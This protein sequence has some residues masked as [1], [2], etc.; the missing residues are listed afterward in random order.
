MTKKHSTKKALMASLLSL[1]LCVSML[2]GT[3]FAWFTDTVTSGS[4]VIQ[5]GSLDIVLEYWDGTQ[6][7]DAEGKV[8]KFL[9]A[10]G[11]D[12]EVL[13]EPGCTYQMPKI[14]VR[15][16]GTLAAYVLIRLNGIV[17][18]EKLLEVVKLTNTITNVP[19]SMLTGSQANVYQKFENATVDLMYG[20]P[21]GTLIFDW[22]LMG[23]GVV[24]PNSGNTDTTAE[25]TV[26]G[27]MDESAGNEYQDLKIEGI[28]VTVLATQ[29][30]YEY[31]S[32]G[33]EYDKEA[34]LPVVEIKPSW[35]GKTLEEPA[36]DNGVYQV[37]KPSELA[38]L[39]EGSKTV[40]KIKFLDNIDMAGATIDS[41]DLT[42]YH[43]VDG[44]GKKISNI[45]VN[46]SGLFGN[47]I[48][49]GNI[50]NIILD[51]ITVNTASGDYAGV[52]NGKYSGTYTDVTVQN[53][54]VNAPASEYVG[55]MAGAYYK[56]ITGCKVD[57]VSVTGTEKV[58]GLIGFFT[59]A[60]IGYSINIDNC[61]VNNVT[62]TATNTSKP[63]AGVIFGRGLATGSYKFIF[64]NCSAGMK[65]GQVLLGQ[66]YYNNIDTSAITV[67]TIS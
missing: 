67:T 46:G 57:N 9:K 48:A 29:T 59:L 47:V 37:S 8:L 7:L 1:V 2:M 30:V 33:R 34:K 38:W 41:I 28:S 25:F 63:Y 58:G 4:N 12:D 49:D 61:S 36:I 20:T 52:V 40:Q 10:D 3:T 45:V 43:T 16:V 21:D 6:W 64:T 65:A 26:S 22:P 53:S 54:R 55:G 15:N 13:W 42:S 24:S 60:D 31:D 27:H 50:K 62:V 39:A 14:R 35:D 51:N 56:N 32:F 23:A 19:Q 44:N 18:D 5:S 66:D 17:G 11:S